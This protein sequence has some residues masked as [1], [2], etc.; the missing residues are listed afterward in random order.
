MRTIITV[1]VG[2]ALAQQMDLNQHRKI[3]FITSTRPS[4]AKAQPTS[5]VTPIQSPIKICSWIHH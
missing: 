1:A 2:W 3:Q 5:G 4:W